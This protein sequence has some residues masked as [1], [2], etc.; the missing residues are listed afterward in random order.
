VARTIGAAQDI[1]LEHFINLVS[2]TL[3]LWTLSFSTLRIAMTLGWMSRMSTARR[4]LKRRLRSADGQDVTAD[5]TAWVADPTRPAAANGTLRDLY[6][7][8]AYRD[9]DPEISFAAR[10]DRIA[11]ASQRTSVLARVAVW[12]IPIIGFLGTVLGIS[13]AIGSFGE[14]SAAS[15]GVAGASGLMTHF[16]QTMS[17]VMTGLATAFNTTLIALALVIP[18]AITVEI[19]GVTEEAIR[20]HA[21]LRLFREIWINIAATWRARQ[22]DSEAP[23]AAVARDGLGAELHHLSRQLDGLGVRMS[24]LHGFVGDFG[25]QVNRLHTCISQLEPVADDQTSRGG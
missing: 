25:Q 10:T 7:S 2:I 20:T 1:V 14:L 9:P 18:V 12:A 24:A 19:A 17:E 16:Q 4:Q 6:E 11:D 15:A 22:Q 8:L 13:Q 23:A 5:L 21:R 3:A